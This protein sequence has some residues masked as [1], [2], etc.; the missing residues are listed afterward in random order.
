MT[1]KE[2]IKFKKMVKKYK[3]LTIIFPASIGFVILLFLMLL[4]FHT[5]STNIKF[6]G[7]GMV[8]VSIV[9][10]FILDLIRNKE[11][12]KIMEHLN[13]I[14]TARRLHHINLFEKLIEE[15]DFNGAISHYFTFLYRKDPN[16][17]YLLGYFAAKIENTEYFDM[18]FDRIDKIN[19]NEK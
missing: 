1:R 14:K 15:Y 19:K 12:R 17:L 7:V 10:L 5:L 2:R 11:Y 3:R 6:A 18:L 13:K 4:N 16:Y 9:A 8:I